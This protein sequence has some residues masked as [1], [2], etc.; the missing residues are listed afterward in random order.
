MN[1]HK[2]SSSKNIEEKQLGSWIQ[3]QQTYYKKNEKSMKDA[4]KRLL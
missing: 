1:E 4:N 3:L 2:K